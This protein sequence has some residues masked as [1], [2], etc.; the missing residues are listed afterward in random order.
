VFYKKNFEIIK[1][2]NGSILKLIKFKI[3]SKKK[4]IYINKINPNVVKGWNLHKRYTCNIFLIKGDME[5]S[6][7]NNFK[8]GK[9]KKIKL[10]LNKNNNLIIK[11]NIWFSFRS[12]SKKNEAIFL[13]MTDGHHSSR[14]ILKKPINRF[15]NPMIS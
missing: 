4:E 13:N 15:K 7:C 1:N 3:K 14:E 11:P 9:I 12:T 8:R 6:I 2:S 10:S 5:F